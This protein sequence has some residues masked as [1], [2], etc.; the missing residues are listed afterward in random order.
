MKLEQY[1]QKIK[2]RLVFYQSICLL[3][4][5]FWF[6]G[7]YKG[8]NN[9]FVAGFTIGVLIGIELVIIRRLGKMKRALK[10]EQMLKMMYVK[11]NDEREQM[12]RLKSGRPFITYLS[13]IALVATILASFFNVTVFF[14]LFAVTICELL[15]S[16]GAK[17]YWTKKI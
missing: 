8:S 5:C 9:D 17:V 11:E 6:V 14:T 4:I 15:I 3:A 13:L 2:Q 1:R 16:F 12:I 7:N 10:D